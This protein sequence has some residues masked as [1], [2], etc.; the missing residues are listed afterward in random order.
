MKIITILGSTRK[1][2][3][4]ASVL[5]QFEV[6]AS[7]SHEVERINITD[8]DVRGCLGCNV[9]QRKAGK[10]GCAERDDAVAILERLLAADVIVYATPLY[11]WSFSAQ[12]KALLDR[13]Y[14]L[15][16]WSE[17]EQAVTSLFAGKRAALLVTCGGSIEEDADLIR[18][19]F[20]RAMAFAGCQVV[21]KYVVPQ[22]T[23]PAQLGDSA[24]NTAR[25]MLWDII[26]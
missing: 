24:A 1:H 20:D 5:E 13:Q 7:S 23:E 17:E 16:K 6:S 14:C 9:C 11:V 21:G 25:E 10:P 2:G 4:T 26:G 18:I 8:Y 15:V 22:C 3:N 12:M 19:A